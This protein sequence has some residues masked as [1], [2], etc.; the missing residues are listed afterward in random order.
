MDTVNI[1]YIFYMEI[2]GNWLIGPALC[3]ND[4]GM[5]AK[6]KAAAPYLVTT[7]WKEHSNSWLTN[8][9]ITVKCSSKLFKYGVREI[10]T[11]VRFI[12]KVQLSKIQL[13]C[14]TTPTS[15]F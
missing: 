10:T 5:Y 15:G 3:V 14:P 6:N 2:V 9:A 13:L 11:S 12:L 8:L 7:S 4:A 1:N